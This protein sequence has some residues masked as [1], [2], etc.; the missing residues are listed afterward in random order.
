[1]KG[2]VFP[3]KDYGDFTPR[4]RQWLLLAVR[5]QHTGLGAMRMAEGLHQR[6]GTASVDLLEIAEG[7]G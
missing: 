1:M 5:P 2:P 3:S 4:I 7:R 6:D